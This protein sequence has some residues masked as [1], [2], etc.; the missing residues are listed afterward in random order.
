MSW[1]KDTLNKVQEKSSK[2]KETVSNTMDDIQRKA[3][4]VARTAQALGHSFTQT[5]KE[6]AADAQV[7]FE[8]QAR[9]LQRLLNSRDT[10]HRW[11]QGFRGD[12]RFIAEEKADSGHITVRDL[13]FKQ[14]FLQSQALEFCIQSIARSAEL[15]KHLLP[16][17][18]GDENGKESSFAQEVYILFSN[19]M[20]EPQ[21]LWL[22]AFCLILDDGTQSRMHA[23][24]F[25]LLHGL[26]L[27]WK[28]AYLLDERTSLATRKEILRQQWA[29]RPLT[30]DILEKRPRVLFQSLHS[31]TERSHSSREVCRL[32]VSLHDNLLASVAQI[33]YWTRQGGIWEKLQNELAGSIDDL[34]HSS[35]ERASTEVDLAEGKSSMADNFE[36][37]MAQLSS[38]KEFLAKN[39]DDIVKEKQDLFAQLEEVVRKLE[40][41]RSD[42]HTVLMTMKRLEE[43]M[44][45]VETHYGARMRLENERKENLL[46][47]HAGLM[48]IS[49][50]VGEA[51]S[52]FSEKSSK[53]KADLETKA[54]QTHARLVE[55]AKAH[56]IVEEPRLQ[57]AIRLVEICVE[58]LEDHMKARNATRGLGV[59]HPVGESERELVSQLQQ[60]LRSRDIIW[61]EIDRFQ[62]LYF[63]ILGGETERKEALASMMK[64]HKDAYDALA[65][66][67]LKHT[68]VHHDP[69]LLENWK[70][71]ASSSSAIPNGD[72][73]AAGM[74]AA[75]NEAPSPSMN[76]NPSSERI[77]AES[78]AVSTSSLLDGVWPSADRQPVISPGPSAQP[79][80]T[81]PG[82]SAQAQTQEQ[83]QTQERMR[84]ASQEPSQVKAPSPAAIM[85]PVSLTAPAKPSSPAAPPAEPSKPVSEATEPVRPNPTSPAAHPAPPKPT[86]PAAQPTPP[87]SEAP[88][89]QPVPPKPTAPVVQPTLPK[90]ASPAPQPAPPQPASPTPASPTVP[91][92]SASKT[93]PAQGPPSAAQLAAGKVTQVASGSASDAPQRNG[94]SAAQLAAAQV[95]QAAAL[96]PSTAAPSAAQLAAKQAALLAQQPHPSTAQAAATVAAPKP[97][98][99]AES[100]AAKAANLVASMSSG[101]S[102]LD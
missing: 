39:I 83:R 46:K 11:N 28:E 50:L 101:G 85:T 44:G 41:A 95:A 48:A 24:L 86:S 3:G 76:A 99:P 51:A 94:M 32:S 78:V 42:H 34:D 47:N 49:S 19:T 29:D 9:G 20:R 58:Q 92:A 64:T 54:E 22:Q 84:A 93:P 23:S 8:E 67:L 13:H 40:E 63:T 10:V 35:A 65:L 73:R 81:I 75:H 82:L 43:E 66:S 69:F 74:P 6:N 56:L 2:W 14:V 36:T 68:E 52:G 98:A 15:R 57:V 55:S 1:F 21:S 72:N 53:R 89:T 88:T 96:A 87:K 26:K 33:Q 90:S 4:D 91:A 60:A 16:F 71:P 38:R 7:L 61:Q 5:Q 79:A 59:A 70:H 62:T 12:Q 17:P 27:D 102:L 31:L 45:N 25:Q 100:G 77:P 18:P 37:Q 80:A 97:A 30:A